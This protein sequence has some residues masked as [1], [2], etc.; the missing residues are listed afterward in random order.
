[1]NDLLG[2]RDKVCVV[3]GAASGIGLAA[4]QTLVALGAQVYAV[5]RVSTPVDG[6]AGSFVT[7]LA[8]RGEIDDVFEHVP[9]HIDAFFGV[10]GV[11]GTRHD[12]AST[13]TINFA[14]NVYI[15]QTYLHTRVVDAGSIAYV[16]SAGGVNWEKY[17]E[18]T[19]P[20]VAARGWHGLLDAIAALGPGDAPGIMAYPLSKRAL[21]LYA[22][23]TAVAYAPRLVRVNSVMPCSTDTGMTGE[24]ASMVG[25]MDNLVAHAGFAGR[26]A[27]PAEMALPL[28]FLGS[29]MAAFVSGVTLPV[30]LAGRAA[31]LLGQAP[32]PLDIP[33]VGA[34]SASAEPSS[35]RPSSPVGR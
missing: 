3:T 24:F 31:Q 29:A 18:E 28:V 15:D 6:L 8:R 4:T 1:M 17:A 14:A 25:G 16:T 27:E 33:L 10:A 35:T 7:N 5:D 11:S 32:D 21:N 9:E 30:D 2:Y 19:T 23:R 13:L 22:A 26:L 12:F 34:G 20:L